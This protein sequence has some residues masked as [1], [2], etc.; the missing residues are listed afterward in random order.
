MT[1][2]KMR[3]VLMTS[4]ECGF[5]ED[6]AKRTSDLCTEG[7]RQRGLH[8]FEAVSAVSSLEK[9]F[10]WKLLSKNKNHHL[11]L[12]RKHKRKPCSCSHTRDKHP[13]P[14]FKP[15]NFNIGY[16][17]LREH[18]RDDSFFNA[19]HFTDHDVTASNGEPG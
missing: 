17:V 14:S 6:D 13:S 1:S 8:R 9:I 16:H 12:R 7:A 15:K 10:I 2:R 18:V 4:F 3:I 19:E 11:C 5:V